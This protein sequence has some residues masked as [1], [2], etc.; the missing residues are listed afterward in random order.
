MD[1]CKTYSLPG[2]EPIPCSTFIDIFRKAEKQ[3]SCTKCCLI[4]RTAYDNGS[5]K[6]NKVTTCCC[7]EDGENEIVNNGFQKFTTCCCISKY[8]GV[9]D[10]SKYTMKNCCCCAKVDS[11]GEY[12][13][14][15]YYFC[16]IGYFASQVMK[17][18]RYCCCEYITFV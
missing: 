6:Q 5:F 1:Y 14:K 13:G 12:E 2:V 11:E 15:G 7:F 4:M 18:F 9:N 3:I 16:G 17:S 10:K 8:N